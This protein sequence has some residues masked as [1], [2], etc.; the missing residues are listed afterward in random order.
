MARPVVA[1]FLIGLAAA[2]PARGAEIDVKAGEALARRHCAEC[3]TMG[4]TRAR[5]L[6]PAF[7][8]LAQDPATT[9]ASLKFLLTHPHYA[10]PNLKLN[11]DEQA[12]II[13]YIMSLRGKTQ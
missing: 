4:Q 12:E 11:G 6:P 13:A 8:E 7:A 9:E 3:H 5:E 1:A 10:M 2:L